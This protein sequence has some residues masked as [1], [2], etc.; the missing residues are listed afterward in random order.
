MSKGSIFEEKFNKNVDLY[1]F[2]LEDVKVGSIIEYSYKVHSEFFFRFPSW[3]FQE[4]I[5]VLWSEYRADIPEF[6]MYEKYMQGYVMAN[7][8]ENERVNSSDFSYNAHRWVAKDVPAFK[9]EPFM[10]CEDDYISRINF[11]LSH[12]KLS[13]VVHD[14]MGSW[15]KLREN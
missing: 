12:Y 1:K 7:I 6:F 8:A 10:T 11:A 2:A 4:K 15:E 14:V 13:G 9:N 5:P 3:Q